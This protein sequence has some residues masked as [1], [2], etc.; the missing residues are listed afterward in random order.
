MYEP[1]NTDEHLEGL[2]KVMMEWY[3][4][5]HFDNIPNDILPDLVD[6]LAGI[7]QNEENNQFYLLRVIEDIREKTGIGDKVMLADLAGV[8]GY[9]LHQGCDD[10]QEERNKQLVKRLQQMKGV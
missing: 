1:Q 7:I 5:G 10:C 3:K 8:L 6:T 4:K 2:N 9:L